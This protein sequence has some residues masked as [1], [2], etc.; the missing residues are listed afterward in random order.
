MRAVRS[1]TTH[2]TP[3]FRRSESRRAMLFVPWLGALHDVDVV[4]VAGDACPFHAQTH[5]HTH[6]THMR[7]VNHIHSQTSTFLL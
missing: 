4:I 6:T 7:T 5:K 1:L 2:N 3:L